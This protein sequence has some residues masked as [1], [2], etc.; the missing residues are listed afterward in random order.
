MSSSSWLDFLIPEEL[1]VEFLVRGVSPNKPNARNELALLIQREQAKDISK[2]KDTHAILN[3]EHEA[4]ICRDNYDLFVKLYNKLS[5]EVAIET[6]QTLLVRS[7]HWVERCER[8][9]NSNGEQFNIIA[10]FNL[11]KRLYKALNSKLQSQTSVS[12]KNQGS[13]QPCRADHST[14]VNSPSTSVISPNKFQRSSKNTN[15]LKLSVDN[16]G[17]SSDNLLQLSPTTNADHGDRDADNSRN[18]ELGESQPTDNFNQ[19]PSAES[20]TSFDPSLAHIINVPKFNEL[21]SDLASLNHNHQS[22]RNNK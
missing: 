3:P 8:L 5:D 6:L 14:V 13:Q 9:K 17:E 11:W 19:S 20:S 22:A 7:V 4:K 15:S 21:N 1:V 2:P 10:T 12:P 16:N 18:L